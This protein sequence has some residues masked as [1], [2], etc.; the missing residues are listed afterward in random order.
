MPQ[1][2]RR[3]S[4][5]G[6]LPIPPIPADPRGTGDHSGGRSGRPVWPH[7]ISVRFCVSL[8][9]C[10]FEFWS[11]R[12]QFSASGDVR[13]SA[14]TYRPL[15]LFSPVRRSKPAAVGIRLRKV[16]CRA[17]RCVSPPPTGQEQIAHRQTGSVSCPRHWPNGLMTL[18]PHTTGKIFLPAHFP[19]R[20][21]RAAHYH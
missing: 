4:R 12:R 3:R 5:L 21:N 6:A 15:L 7:E 13:S 1:R 17:R 20:E 8:F 14:Y 19:D 18:L 16:W 10:G 11:M 9:M 2:S